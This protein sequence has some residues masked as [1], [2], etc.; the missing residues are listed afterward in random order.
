MVGIDLIGLLFGAGF[1]L[2]LLSLGGLI[3]DMS[4]GYHQ[5]F[6]LEL[7]DFRSELLILRNQ[8]FFP[9]GVIIDLAVLVL[10]QS[11][12]FLNPLLELAVLGVDINDYLF[13]GWVGV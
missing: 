12:H 1:L 9:P 11:R 7:C 5:F 4:S 3:G 8:F 2:Y 13:V 10:D 6:I